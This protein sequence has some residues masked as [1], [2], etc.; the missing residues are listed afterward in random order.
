M[1]KLYNKQIYANCIIIKTEALTFKILRVNVKAR[2][3]INL[4][5]RKALMYS[6]WIRISLLTP[7]KFIGIPKRYSRLFFP[8]IKNKCK[9]IVHSNGIIFIMTDNTKIILIL[10]GYIIK[11]T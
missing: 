8:K 2:T 7:V 5:M 4:W 11:S 6:L 10:P 1:M 9:N 3:I